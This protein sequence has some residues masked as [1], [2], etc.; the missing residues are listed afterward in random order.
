MPSSACKP[1]P[2]GSTLF[3]YTTL[4]RSGGA[5]HPPGRAGGR[6]LRRPGPAPGPGPDLSC[7]CPPGAARRAHRQP[8]C[9]YRSGGDHRPG[10][11]GERSEEHTSE[12]QSRPHL[13]CRLLLA[14]RHHRAPHSF[15]T[16]RSSDL[17]GLDTPLGERGAGLS[18][19][20]AQRL[21]L[22]RIFLADAPLVLLDE[23]TASLDADTEAVVITALEALARQGRTLVIATHHPA[24]IAMAGRRLHLAEGRLEEVTHVPSP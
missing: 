9:R 21:A 15:P 23:P 3:P 12:L 16:R 18:G 1:P 4:F 22:A 8:G 2:P 19:G 11:P 5:R 20:Q 7:R 24:L 10:G 14:N 6:P 17:E 13:V